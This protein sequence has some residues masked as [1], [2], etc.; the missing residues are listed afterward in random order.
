MDTEEEFS[1]RTKHI[2]LKHYHCISHMKCGSVDIHY[3]PTGEKLADL[4]T[5]PFSNKAFLPFFT[6]SVDEVTPNNQ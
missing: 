2:A 5:K 1:P 6:C 4:L 3:R